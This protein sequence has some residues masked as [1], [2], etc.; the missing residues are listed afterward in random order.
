[1]LLET[2]VKAEAVITEDGRPKDKKSLIPVAKQEFSIC[3]RVF[4]PYCGGKVRIQESPDERLL[5]VLSK[6]EDPFRAI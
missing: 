4:S 5:R 1:M 2:T 3:W 6:F